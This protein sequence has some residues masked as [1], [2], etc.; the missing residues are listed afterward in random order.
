M[1]LPSDPR[2]RRADQRDSHGDGLRNHPAQTEGRGAPE[3]G[4]SLTPGPP[5]SLTSPAVPTG[6]TGLP[7]RVSGDTQN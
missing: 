6:P 4:R 3:E 7:C 2:G 5:R 1:K